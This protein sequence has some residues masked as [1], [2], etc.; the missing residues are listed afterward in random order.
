MCILNPW[1]RHLITDSILNSWLFGSAKLTKNVTVDKYKY[2]RY[3]VGFDSR[4]EFSL[5]GVSMGNNVII[6]AFDMIS[7]VHIDNKKIYLNFW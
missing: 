1:L 6:F 4:F 3:R 2:S 7:F 5:T